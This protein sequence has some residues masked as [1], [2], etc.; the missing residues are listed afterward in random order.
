MAKKQPKQK[1]EHMQIAVLCYDS[2]EV[3]I[4]DVCI[5]NDNDIIE[6]WLIEHCQYNLDQ[7]SWMSASSI[8]VNNLT[9]EDFGN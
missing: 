6:N 2:S 1:K 9:P 8:K 5:E 3:D 7:I 4:I